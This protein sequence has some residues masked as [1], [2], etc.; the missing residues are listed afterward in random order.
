[1][2][3]GGTIQHIEIEG[4]K[5]VVYGTPPELSENDPGYHNCDAMGCPSF[6]HVLAVWALP[7]GI[8]SQ[9]PSVQP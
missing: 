6:D 5:V 8:T 2:K 1:M 3:D 9:P 7:E 4:G